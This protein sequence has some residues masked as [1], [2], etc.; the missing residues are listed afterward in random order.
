[1]NMDPLLWLAGATL[2]G[3][4]LL[5]G[6]LQL[7][8]RLGRPG[9]A[10]VEAASRAPLL[11]VVVFVYTTAPLLGALAVG[12][13]VYGSFLWT[14]AAL[15]VAVAAQAAAMM[16]WIGLHE[17]A[18]PQA[19]R[20]PRIVSSLNRA[21]GPWR[22]NLAVWWTAWAIPVFMIVRIAELLVYPPLVWLIGLPRYKQAEW[23]NVSRHKF[24][25]LIGYDRLWCLYCDWMTGIW[26]LGSEMLRNIESFWCPIRFSSQ[27]KCENCRIDFPDVDGG[28]VPADG[29]MQ[30]V[31]AVLEKH[32][33]AETNGW[34]GHPARLTV[35]GRELNQSA[36]ISE[37][38][39]LH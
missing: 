21:V 19:R 2:A 26:S 30:D 8:G 23:V 7:A 18:H 39:P 17:L 34:F 25:G 1:M 12:L 10:L 9:R 28:W 33:P 35:E 31:V 13:C 5:A 6:L 36:P 27:A 16:I 3:I 4:L 20:G 14:L 24:D 37:S 32:Y 22:N 29:T 11:D 38:K 15:A